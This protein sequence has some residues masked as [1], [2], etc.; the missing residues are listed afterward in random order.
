MP[1]ISRPFHFKQFTL[2]QDQCAHKVGTDGILLAAWAQAKEA[3]RIL[4][5]GHGSGLISIIAAQRFPKAEVW[6]IE[7]DTAS[8]EQSLNNAQ[9][10]PFTERL[11][12]Q[13]G[14]FE[15]ELLPGPFDLI[16]ANPPYFTAQ[17]PSPKSERAGARTLDLGMLRIWIRKWRELIKANGSLAV[18]LPPETWQLANKI[19][20]QEDWYPNRI[21]EVRHHP[22]A[23]V[24][25]LLLEFCTTRQSLK[26]EELI[27]YNEP[28]QT[29]RAAEWQALVEDI[30]IPQD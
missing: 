11:F 29:K 16:L 19:F 13:K 17:V 20:Y 28:N 27:L 22:E 14:D 21:C 30:M 8:Y 15:K 5:F 12:F 7:V 18:I 4:D 9:N 3:E 1:K 26:E 23:R 25:R 10:S 6:G 24:K 2:E